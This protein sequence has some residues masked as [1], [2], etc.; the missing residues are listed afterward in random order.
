MTIW[1]APKKNSNP[2]LNPRPVRAR[3]PVAADPDVYDVEF[4]VAWPLLDH[5]PPVVGATLASPEQLEVS[6][7]NGALIHVTVTLKVTSH[8]SCL[9]YYLYQPATA[10]INVR[11]LVG[12]GKALPSRKSL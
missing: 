8:K 6:G 5:Q 10:V 4:L 3:R 11:P 9:S 12:R 7:T 1:P 2:R